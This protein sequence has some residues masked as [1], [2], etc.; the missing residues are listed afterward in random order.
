MIE[1]VIGSLIAAGM[2]A[3][4]TFLYRR[5]YLHTL[6]DDVMFQVAPSGVR[7]NRLLPK[8]T[9]NLQR[10]LVRWLL[11]DQSRI[12]HHRGQYG[13][14]CD[15]M[16]SEKWQSK[17]S[18]ENLNLKPRMYL[19]Y[20]PVIIL[21]K[22][23]IAPKS[24]QLAINGVA[25][26]FIDGLIPLY[27]SAPESSPTSREQKWNLRHSMAGAHL[28]AV[29]NPGNDITRSVVDQML[30]TRNSWQ[31]NTGGWWQTS[32][33]KGKPDLWASVYALKL[34]YFIIHEKQ[35]SFR[36]QAPLVE[37]IINQTLLFLESE[38]EKNLWGVSGRLLAEENLMTMFIDL[39]P[40]LLHYS[41][42]LGA[43]CINSMKKWLSPGGDLSKSYLATLETQSTPMYPKQAYARMAYAFYLSQDRFV[44]WKPW[45][46]KVARA[47]C[48]RLFSS[49]SAFL[50]DLSFVYENKLVSQP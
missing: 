21:H 45:F 5:G 7:E 41:P 33:R 47:S 32:D 34:L 24:V 26:L 25:K 40:I 3:L 36:D 10:R 13:K 1:G 49:E 20:W 43:K 6:I 39:A 14:S 19:T 9:T 28:L 27:T 8:E 17:G 46:E 16:L 35:D 22:H 18:G 37:D 12:G 31:G 15:A 23:R 48:D 30:D 50:L 11:R 42:S 2:A 44:D 38:W 4:M 29:G